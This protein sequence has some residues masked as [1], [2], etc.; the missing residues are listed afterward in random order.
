[1]GRIPRYVKVIDL[2][3]QATIQFGGDKYVACCYVLTLLSSLTKHMTVS[4]DYY[5]NI[6]RLKAA[7]VND[8]SERVA[9]M[10]SIEVLRIAAAHNPRYATMMYFSDDAKEQTW[11]LSGELNNSTQAY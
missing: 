7:S 9:D 1:M 4:A 3:C 10:E 6:A 2:L 5:R 11:S 8:F